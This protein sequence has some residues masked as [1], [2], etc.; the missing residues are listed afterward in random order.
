MENR[1][2]MVQI[3]N[4]QES[5]LLLIF[6]IFNGNLS[7][8]FLTLAKDALKFICETI[9][10]CVCVQMTSSTNWNIIRH[11]LKGELHRCNGSL[12]ESRTFCFRDTP[13]TIV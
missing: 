10:K 11:A 1:K 12:L 3:G 2:A 13:L 5:Y 7:C 6:D 4:H 9:V 8:F